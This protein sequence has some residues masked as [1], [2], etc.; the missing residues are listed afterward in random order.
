[1]NGVT[2]LQELA[3]QPYGAVS[4]AERL[5]RVVNDRLTLECMRSGIRT[6]RRQDRDLEDLMR[7][8]CRRD[9]SRRVGCSSRRRSRSRCMPFSASCPCSSW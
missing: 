4:N 7:G 5:V 8:T 2:F 1:M 9:P 6:M 3:N